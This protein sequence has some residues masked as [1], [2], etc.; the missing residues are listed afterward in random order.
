MYLITASLLNSW[1]YLLD[2]EYGNIED[3]K[4]VLEKVPTPTTKAIETGFAFEKWCEQYFEETKG[5][6]FQVTAKKVIGDYL[7][8]G[9]VDCIKAGVIYDYKYTANYETGKF[10]ENPQTAMYL[11]LIPEAQKM[12]YIISNTN[13]FSIE[14]LYRE[15]YTRPEIEPIRTTVNQFMTWIN[16][17][18]YSMEKWI[19]K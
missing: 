13:K 9:R 16:A 5:G 7:L 10:L 15:D 6:M 4:K 8:Y 17:N 3:F 2:S 18:G 12:S 11:E 14:N 1:R 19:T